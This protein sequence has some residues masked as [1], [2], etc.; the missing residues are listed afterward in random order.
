MNCIANVKN[1]VYQTNKMKLPIIFIN[2]MFIKFHISYV[3]IRFLLHD[4]I[5][6]IKLKVYS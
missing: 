1:N 5:T 4:N 3:T 6:S 2:K